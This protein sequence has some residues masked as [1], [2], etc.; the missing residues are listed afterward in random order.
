MR[1]GGIS[2]HVARVEMI[3]QIIDTQRECDAVFL[4]DL[5]FLCHFYIERDE[6]R[7]ASLVCVAQSDEVLLRVTNRVRKT[8]AC[9][10]DGR[11][12]NVTRE[13]ERAPR[14]QAIRGGKRQDVKLRLAQGGRRG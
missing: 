2:S 5:K 11:E 7:E 6:A 9:F 3:G 4:R 10:K 8:V 14:Q 12:R 1:V 13:R